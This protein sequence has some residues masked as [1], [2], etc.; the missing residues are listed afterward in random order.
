M[1]QLKALV[2]TQ[3]RRLRLLQRVVVVLELVQQLRLVVLDLLDVQRSAM[4]LSYNHIIAIVVGVLFGGWPGTA[5][6]LINL[7][8][9]LLLSVLTQPQILH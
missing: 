6:L 9:L 1:Q 4:L 3:H 8:L 2:V 7:L 5:L